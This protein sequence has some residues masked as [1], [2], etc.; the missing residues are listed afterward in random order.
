MTSMGYEA[1]EQ[2]AY[3][4]TSPKL[5]PKVRHSAAASRYLT[6]T[7]RLYTAD[8]GGAASDTSSVP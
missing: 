1:E 2:Y 5:Q 6:N 7:A 8:F 4:Q 3:I